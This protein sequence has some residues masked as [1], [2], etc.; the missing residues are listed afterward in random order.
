MLKRQDKSHP[1]SRYEIMALAGVLILAGVLRFGWVGVNSFG[2]DEARLSQ[3]ALS[4]ARAGKFA[5]LGMQSSARIPNFPAAAWLY[6]LPYQLSPDPQL[7][8]WFTGLLSI[9]AVVGVW[10]LARETWGSSAGL[11]AAL[12]CAASPYMVF[13]SRSIWAQDFL[14]PL[15]VLWACTG[16]WG[17][18]KEQDWAIALHAFL[19]G[20]ILQVHF[21]GAALLIGSLWLGLRYR[22]WR[23]WK[24]IVAGGMAALL[25]AAPTLYTLWRGN[26]W[27]SLQEIWQQPTLQFGWRG[28]H[29]LGELGAGLNWEH[30]WLNAAWSW[31]EPLETALTFANIL[32]GAGLLVG[33]VTC[34]WELLTGLMSELRRKDAP[35]PDHRDI[36]TT[37]LPVW[38]IAA[39]L[40]FLQS[41]TWLYIH[42]Q[43]ASLPALFLAVGSLARFSR[44][45]WWKSLLITVTLA[46]ALAQSSAVAQTLSIEKQRLVAGG[47]GT[48]LLYPQNAIAALRMDD[49]PIIV[50]TYGDDIEF[51]GDAATFHVLL[52]EYPH[53]I[54][55]A[56]AVLLIPEQPAHLFTSYESLAAWEM[57]RML[58][59]PG[60]TREF[61]RREGE[62][63]Y[64]ALTTDGGELA[65]AGFHPVGPFRLANG[66]E[67]QGW[68][69]QPATEDRGIRL[70]THWQLNGPIQE[71]QYHQFNH[72][73]LQGESTPLVHDINTSSHA[74]LPDAHLI[75][76][77]DFEPAT[78]PPA[79]IDIGMYT[80]PDLQRSPVLNRPGDPLAPIR[81]DLSALERRGV[82]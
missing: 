62:P 1:L 5:T 70:V 65:E 48:P 18:S 21:A 42:Y 75:T 43:L 19:A 20:F 45:R 74:W 46:I 54:V 15:A 57:A 66:A 55:D 6:A 51:D 2:F 24:A 8:I 79:Y 7:A 49:K 27:A 26:V 77:V 22:L 80:W 47:M 59:V 52:W 28:F 76:W 60:V 11:S 33:F 40:F 69:I 23:Q 34:T 12:L 58:Q 14:A 32:V 64:L 4:M 53:Q 38:A 10:W 25:A 44:R 29:Y 68:Q 81:L 36:L 30:L 73:Y 71:G 67:L 17:I 56:H 82:Q 41:K 35:H 37:L 61:P 9:L 39:P 72:L 3:I 63:S 13:Y 50:H 31:G 16:V 78:A